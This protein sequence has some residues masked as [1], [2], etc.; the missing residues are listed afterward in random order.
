MKLK[1]EEPPRIFKVGQQDTIIKDCAKILLEP[2]EQVTFQIPSG[3]EYDVARK[4]WGF[5]ATPSLNG[6]LK[7]FGFH[8][9]LV[10]NSSEHYFLWIVEDGKNEEFEEYLRSETHTIV[11]WMDTNAQLKN[12]EQTIQSKKKEYR[13]ICGNSRLES[14]YTYHQ[15]PE[16]EVSFE[17]S[18][19]ENYYR[20]LLRCGICGHFRSVHHMNMENLYG[21]KYVDATYKSDAGIRKAFNRISS[22]PPDRSDNEGRVRR[23]LDLAKYHW[24]ENESSLNSP[25]ILDVGSGLCVFLNRLKQFGWD[26]TA[27]DPDSRAALHAEKNVGVKSLCTEFMN[28]EVTELFDV[29]TFNKVLEHVEDP[30][31][32]LARCASFLGSDGFVYIELPDGE[33]AYNEGPNREEFTID[34]RHVFSLASA[35]ILSERAGFS[36]LKLERFREPSSKY[37]ICAFLA[38][39]TTNHELSKRDDNG[40]EN[41]S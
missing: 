38:V 9:V 35:A 22:L 3:G 8:A 29:I 37:T 32:M 4:E 5:Y 34:H 10:K 21:G 14:L 33:R 31:S 7:K 17:F 12:I 39:K 23:I 1:I 40:R 30:G 36:I 13:C 19:K 27:L 15:P 28:A 25:K 16:Q 20:R 6:R 2:D 24:K 41:L 26:C 18:S 11:A